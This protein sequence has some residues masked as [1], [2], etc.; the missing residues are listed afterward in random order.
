MAHYMC[1]FDIADAVGDPLT[2][3]VEILYKGDH[4]SMAELA[5]KMAHTM[6]DGL[7]KHCGVEISQYTVAGMSAGGNERYATES[8]QKIDPTT[9]YHEQWHSTVYKE[10]FTEHPAYVP[11]GLTTLDE[12]MAHAIGDFC[13]YALTKDP[14]LKKEKQNVVL[15]NMSYARGVNE[16]YAE[17]KEAQKENSISKKLIDKITDFETNK[18]TYKNQNPGWASF[19]GSVNDMAFYEPCMETI[20][21]HGLDK[22][23]EIFLDA[24]KLATDYQSLDTGLRHIT[25]FLEEEKVEK[26][27]LLDFYEPVVSYPTGWRAEV[28]DISVNCNSEN[29]NIDHV[30]EM[31][32]GYFS[33]QLNDS[34]NNSSK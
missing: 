6:S 7:K 13:G 28:G 21:S 24:F 14:A 9:K 1:F 26:M 23:K 3:R 5:E 33:N 34:D 27:G 18:S 11:A 25:S 8:K 15:R 17:V 19:L 22:A 2:S 31:V 16:L 4:T 30:V 10:G 32:V 29:K 12:S 20:F